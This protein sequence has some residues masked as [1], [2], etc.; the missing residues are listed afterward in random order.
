M[1]FLRRA[2]SDCSYHVGVDFPVDGVPSAEWIL[3]ANSVTPVIELPEL[4]LTNKDVWVEAV[5]GKIW[6]TYQGQLLRLPLP[7][8][9]R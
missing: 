2:S 7:A 1:G 9:P 6:I 5:A 3:L 4:R 8:Q